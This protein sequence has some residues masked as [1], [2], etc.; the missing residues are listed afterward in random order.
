MRQAKRIEQRIHVFH[1]DA[2]NDDIG[3]GIVTNRNHQ[4]GNVAKCEPRDA[5]RER[6]GD[7]AS[8]NEI[9]RLQRVE[10]AEFEFALLHLMIEFGEDGDLDGAGRGKHFIG[11]E[12]VF[13]PGGEIENGH[14]QNAVEV[15]IDVL[16][17]GFQLLPKNL[18][19]L[20]RRLLR[21]RRSRKQGQQ[22]N[23][24]NSSE[25]GDLRVGRIIRP[26][27]VERTKINPVL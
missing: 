13:L 18:L 25:H 24:E 23:R 6:A 5:G 3:G 20:L 26:K 12:Q 21:Q 27:R 8:A 4:S 14:R 1:S 9:G 16:D 7:A 19:F 15:A 10:V 11:V 17:C 2:V 22:G